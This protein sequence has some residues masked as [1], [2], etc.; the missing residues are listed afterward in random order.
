M[1]GLAKILKNLQ[2]QSS[3]R[4]LSCSLA[5][6]LAI[7][8]ASLAKSDERSMLTISVVAPFYASSPASLSF[9]SRSTTSSVPGREPRGD[10][11]TVAAEPSSITSGRGGAPLASRRADRHR[12]EVARPPERRGRQGRR[13]MCQHRGEDA[14]PLKRGE[15]GGWSDVPSSAQACCFAESPGRGRR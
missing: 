8:V 3:N 12:R 1:I 10:G 6:C 14:R 7:F 2:K 11:V 9:S 13:I 4:L 5:I 15:G